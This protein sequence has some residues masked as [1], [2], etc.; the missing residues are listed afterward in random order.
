VAFTSSAFIVFLISVLTAFSLS[1]PR[2]RLAL[3]LIAS[4]GFYA[5]AHLPHLTLLLIVTITTWGGAHIISRRR[6]KGRLGVVLVAIV[7]PLLG[8]K[9]YN[10]TVGLVST[11]G[12]TSLGFL[13][14]V[15]PIGISFYTFQAISY[16]TDTYR[17]VTAGNAPFGRL[18]LYLAFFPQIL[19]GPIER[20]NTLLPQ[21]SALTRA[22]PSCTYMGLKYML[23]GFFC[24]LVV[25]DNIALIVDP[26]VETPQQQSG[27]SLIVGF[28]L[29][30]FQIYFDFLGYTNIAIGVARLFGVTLS[31]NFERPYLATSIKDFWRRWHITL[32]TWF[33]DYVYIPLGGTQTRAITRMGQIGI[34]FLLSGLWHGASLN[35]LAWGGLHGSLYLLEGP[36]RRMLS[37]RLTS[38]RVLR[39][40][41][42][43]VQTGL[44]FGAVTAAWV[45]FRLSDFEDIRMVA[46]RV[47]HLDRTIPYT[48]LNA[49]LFELHSLVMLGVLSTALAFDCW[50]VTA[51]V[52]TRV[53][54][55]TREIV[56]EL[57][58]VNWCCVSLVLLGGLGTRDFIYFRF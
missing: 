24:K 40:C 57:I 5:Y 33:R 56:T 11:L 58:F 1:P 47:L 18:A 21:L 41:R 23:W 28:S 7:L 35:F 25:A 39:V 52:V 42:R 19:A 48:V 34:V 51:R 9:Y 54:K 55:N 16:V 8:F 45:L 27:T 37:S 49:T 15:L 2:Y 53:P 22:T 36:L 50:R 14:V 13:D 10:F 46:E 3:L 44:T 32:S 30:S 17:G 38:K 4:Y 12:G 43:I 31:P 29:Y 20:A 6:S 26:I